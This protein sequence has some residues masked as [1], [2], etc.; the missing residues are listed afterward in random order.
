MKNSVV[1]FFSAIALSGCATP[2]PPLPPDQEALY[3]G[4]LTHGQTALSC[5]SLPCSEGF[6]GHFSDFQNL[7]ASQAWEALGVMVARLNYGSDLSYF[8]LGVAAQGLGANEAAIHYYQAAVSISTSPQ[9][10]DQCHS[11][12]IDLC[13]GVA[14]PNDAYARIQVVQAAIDRQRADA[15]ARAAAAAQPPKP[16]HRSKPKDST[17]ENP[18]PDAP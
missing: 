13:N 5:T 6:V 8:Y 14:L 17:W 12:N 10:G 4:Q 2:L 15:A 16:H 18:T 7:Y 9:T 1:L 3:V 11:G